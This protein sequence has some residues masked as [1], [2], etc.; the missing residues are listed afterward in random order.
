VLASLTTVRGSKSEDLLQL[1]ENFRP[2]VSNKANLRRLLD[3]LGVHKI[4]A[5]TEL[6]PSQNGT[7]GQNGSPVQNGSSHHE[8]VDVSAFVL[9]GDD[10]AVVA[11]TE[12]PAF[13]ASL[14]LP[15]A[16]VVD[17]S[18][19]STE[20][21]AIA[22]AARDPLDLAAPRPNLLTYASAPTKAPEGVSLT[23]T[24]EVVDP[25]TLDVSDDNI[26]ETPDRLQN[27]LLV[28]S[29]GFATPEDLEVVALASEHHG[30]PLVGV[31]VADPERSDK[32]SGQQQPRRVMGLHGPRQ[33][34]AL[35]SATR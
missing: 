20:Q 5:R 4:G 21:L 32:T 7:T 9:A 14:G 6:I 29:S 22:C 26:N 19:T 10:K 34:S 12:L 18:N 35:R 16:L 1:L 17:G 2:S 3:E 8:A 13:A 23:V 30:R 28:V 27:A 15:V 25:A 33:L 24:V 31:V 11:I